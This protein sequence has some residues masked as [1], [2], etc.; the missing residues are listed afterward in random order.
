MDTKLEKPI[1]IL[2]V[3]ENEEEV[4][5]L[6]YLIADAQQFHYDVDWVDSWEN[7]LTAYQRQAYDAC[8]VDYGPGVASRLNIIQ[9]LTKGEKRA[10]II[11]ISSQGNYELVQA[12][13]KAGA[14]DYLLM[15]QL[16]LPLL[17]R[18]IHYAIEQQNFQAELERCE[19]ERENAQQQETVERSQ[20]Y[21]ADLENE[22]LFRALTL[23]TSAAIFIITDMHIRYTNPAALAMTGYSQAELTRAQF[24]DLVHPN[25]REALLKTGLGNHWSVDLP[26]RYELKIVRK[27]GSECWL[28]LTTGPLE[29]ENQPAWRIGSGI[30]DARHIR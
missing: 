20:V 14:A 28:D 12:A 8:L 11:F 15:E 16:N 9:G 5:R 19:Q 7:A 4:N 23:N 13:Q 6:K 29:F 25:Y 1:R 22:A 21:E 10:P 26:S 3:D 18:T 2:L 27:D 24:I 17:E 30:D